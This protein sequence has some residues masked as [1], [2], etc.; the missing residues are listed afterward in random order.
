MQHTRR[1]AAS[2]STRYSGCSAAQAI[3]RPWPDPRQVTP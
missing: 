3:C 2:N 1:I